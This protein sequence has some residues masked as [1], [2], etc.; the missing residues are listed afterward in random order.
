MKNRSKIN[1][2][3]VCKIISWMIGAL[4]ILVGVFP[5]LWVVMSS[6]KPL[7][8]IQ[9]V[10]FQ[11]FPKQ[12]TLENYRSIFSS[13]SVYFPSG[14]NF[15]RSIVMTLMVSFIALFLSLTV[16]SLAAY[17]FARLE[18]PGKKILWSVYAATM[19]VPNIA[20]LIPCYYVVSKIGLTDTMAVLILPGVTYVWSIFFFRQFYL[21]IPDVLEEAALLDGCSRIGIYTRIFLPMSKTPFIIMGLSVFQ[22]FW[23]A[24]IWPSMTIINNTS[25][26]QVNQLLAYFRN[27]QGTHWDLLLAGTVITCIPLI[28]MLTVMQKY[29]VQGIKIS[30]VK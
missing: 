5:F 9:S 23:N 1:K 24:Y 11:F 2:H 10:V 28:L 12:W 13:S 16:N 26:Y 6:F 20:I 21:G 29:I 22:G 3:S 27:S 4:L 30:G 7:S 25:L 18:F 17:A 15:L 14:T 19:F 8:E